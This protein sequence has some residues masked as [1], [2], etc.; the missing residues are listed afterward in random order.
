MSPNTPIEL[1]CDE[2]VTVLM[3]LEAGH[4]LLEDTEHAAAVLELEDAAETLIEKLFGDLPRADW[5]ANS[6]RPT[7]MR[8]DP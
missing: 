5:P 3:A 2:A 8:P 6:S 1:T 4:V 7:P